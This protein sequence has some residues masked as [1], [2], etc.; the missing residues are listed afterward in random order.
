ME[1]TGFLATE[2]Q[3]QARP[4]EALALSADL[5]TSPWI[6][7]ATFTSLN[8]TTT[9]FERCRAG[10]SRRLREMERTVI[11]ETEVRPRAL[12]SLRLMVWRGL[13][14]ATFTSPNLEITELGRS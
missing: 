14:R 13:R 9:V 10:S 1:P 11:P 5:P 4:S 3:R 6:R 2:V 7:P 8:P 12:R